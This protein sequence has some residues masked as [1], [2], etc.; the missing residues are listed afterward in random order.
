MWDFV[1]VKPRPCLSLWVSRRLTLVS[2]YYVHSLASYSLTCLSQ[3]DGTWKDVRQDPVIAK[4]FV[5]TGE[6]MTGTGLPAGLKFS[7]V[8]LTIILPRLVT[9]HGRD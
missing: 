4:Y 3:D 2:P 1:R 8:R 5:R 9:R 7:H 6:P